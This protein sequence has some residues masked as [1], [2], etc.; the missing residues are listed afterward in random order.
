MAEEDK[1][2][3]GSLVLDF[4]ISC[5]HVRTIFRKQKKVSLLAMVGQPRQNAT[6]FNAKFAYCEKM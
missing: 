2:F 6:G 5:R 4:G 3:R 1:T